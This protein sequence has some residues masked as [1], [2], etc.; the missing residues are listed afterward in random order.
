MFANL[1]AD[2]RHYSRFCYENRP[3]W[4]VWPHILYAHPA[5][6]AVIWYRFG[7]MAWRLSVPGVREVLQALYLLGLPLVRMYAGVQILPQTL[8]GPGLAILHFG[9]V[10]ITRECEIGENCLLYHNVNLVTMKSR[11][12]PRIGANFYAGVGTTIIG[13]VTIEDNVTCGA[14]SVV[15][16]SVPK[17]AVIAGVPARILRFRK[18]NENNADNQTAPVARPKWMPAPPVTG[19]EH[20]EPQSATGAPHAGSVEHSASTPRG[21]APS[22][23]EGSEH[24]QLGKIDLSA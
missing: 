16:R 12:G 7:S 23:S 24:G 6:A 4:A 11:R 13:E 15:T 1:R 10:V 18:P 9:G 19:G 2:L 8:I 5:A 14:G 17:D 22:D 21:L 3:V 20:Q